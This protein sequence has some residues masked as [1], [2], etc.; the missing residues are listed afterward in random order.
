MKALRTIQ[1]VLALSL[2]SVAAQA[3]K[4]SSCVDYN[5]INNGYE[6]QFDLYVGDLKFTGGIIHPEKA[7]TPE[8][9]DKAIEE[10]MAEYTRQTSG[11]RASGNLIADPCRVIDPFK[12][13]MSD[14]RLALGNDNFQALNRI[15]DQA[16]EKLGMDV[17]LALTPSFMS[18]IANLSKG[19]INGLALDAMGPAGNVHQ[20]FSDILGPMRERAKLM[21]A[22]SKNKD[23][24]DRGREAEQAMNQFYSDV[25]DAMKKKMGQMRWTM[26]LRSFDKH[27]KSRKFMGV[28]VDVEYTASVDMKKMVAQSETF[29]G[30]YLG[31]IT[32][33]A[34]MKPSDFDARFPK[35]PWSLV[36]RAAKRDMNVSTMWS[37]GTMFSLAPNSPTS[38]KLTADLERAGVVARFGDECTVDWQS[39]KDKPELR[40]SYTLDS[41][42]EYFHSV[43]PDYDYRFDSY[44]LSAANPREIHAEGVSFTDGWYIA[45]T[46]ATP[47]RESL[48]EFVPGEWVADMGDHNFLEMLKDGVQII[49][50][51]KEGR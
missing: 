2:V 26:T 50:K 42:R 18:V 15:Y 17:A 29:T 47:A 7:L 49:V 46:R 12:K 28:K 36:R 27:V 14:M 24:I 30:G 35:D 41:A 48:E 38:F 23:V 25:Y 44:R 22:I 32:I 11:G 1:L 13:A 8:D 31:T 39:V 6:C 9:I 19:D 34:E 51:P 45:P 3:Q 33:N 4:Y 16:I 20:I 5:R 21:D 37:P 10:V 40:F 43:S